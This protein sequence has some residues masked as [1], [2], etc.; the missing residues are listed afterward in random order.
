MV[1]VR[2][3]PRADC[4]SGLTADVLRQHRIQERK[5]GAEREIVRHPKFDFVFN[6]LDARAAAI[7]D[8]G[9]AIGPQKRELEVFP[10]FPER[11]AIPTQAVVEPLGF[12]AD[13]IVRQ[14]IR[15]IGSDPCNLRAV[16]AARP[17]SLGPGRIHQFVGREF[18]GHVGLRNGAGGRDVLVEVGAGCKRGRGRTRYRRRR[19]GAQALARHREVGVRVPIETLDGIVILVI[20]QAAIQRPLFGDVPLS[21]EEHRLVAV[22]ALLVGEPYGISEPRD[23][24]AK[25]FRISVGGAAVGVRQSVTRHRVL[26]PD[27]VQLPLN[28]HAGGAFD[29]QVL[30]RGQPQLMAP[31]LEVAFRD[32]Q[33]LRHDGM[34]S[35]K[36]RAAGPVR[37]GGEYAIVELRVI[38]VVGNRMDGALHVSTRVHEIEVADF[39]LDRQ[40]RLHERIRRVFRAEMCDQEI[41]DRGVITKKSIGGQ[42]LTHDRRRHGPIVGYIELERRAAALGVDCVVVL[43]DVG[44]IADGAGA[45]GAHRR[46]RTDDSRDRVLAGRL[47]GPS[48]EGAH[49]V[50]DT[51]VGV[52]AG[53]IADITGI[54]LVP[55]DEADRRDR[56]Q[57]DIDEAF[58]HPTEASVLHMVPFDVI[59]GLELGRIGL[60]G[61][62]ADG[63]RL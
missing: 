24:R 30:R 54:L 34:A 8:D 38:A 43:L 18:V 12:P 51:G 61:D 1:Y 10:V 37:A 44:R 21:L 15:L 57:G 50:L 16:D 6:A 31:F 45:N 49:T 41:A 33:F 9:Q 2:I 46:T 7:L 3:H 23:G 53:H 5:V 39:P 35:R 40:R 32:H 25:S 27:V 14:E 29:R 63:A 58:G 47:A 42:R 48:R 13:L 19:D 26:F 59:A 11:R 36:G 62:D 17:E 56:R 60:V 52:G 55:A 22:D 20:A 4:H 28:E